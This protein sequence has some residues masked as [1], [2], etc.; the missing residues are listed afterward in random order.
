[1][2]KAMQV[3]L[4]ARGRV[5]DLDPSQVARMPASTVLGLLRATRELSG[6]Q[7][8][9]GSLYQDVVLAYD[10]AMLVRKLPAAGDLNRGGGHDGKDPFDPLYR[11][12]H[13]AAF[14]SAKRRYDQ[15][16]AALAEA[17]REDR[18]ASYTVKAVVLADWQM[19]YF[20][21]ALRVGLNHLARVLG[22][23]ETLEKDERAA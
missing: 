22:V 9:A 21:P 3:G 2:E 1:M 16:E 8:E 13:E 19:E 6:R 11:E 14:A 10:R 7:Y 4:E 23:A 17:N 18:H 12:M 20:T 5:F 15:C